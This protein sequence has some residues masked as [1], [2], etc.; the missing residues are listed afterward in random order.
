MLNNIKH[1]CVNVHIIFYLYMVQ[2]VTQYFD[3][4]MLSVLIKGMRNNFTVSD[5]GVVLS[6]K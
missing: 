6:A 1:F 2:Q 5:Y 3:M 4:V